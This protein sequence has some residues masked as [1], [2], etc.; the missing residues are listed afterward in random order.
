MLLALVRCFI[1]Y[2]V[3]R[4]ARKLNASIEINIGILFDIIYC[5]GIKLYGDDKDHMTGLFS[6]LMLL[7]L[8]IVY[9]FVRWVFQNSSLESHF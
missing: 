5:A 6:T 8:S 4:M 1:A 3:N 2:F 9:C 7:R